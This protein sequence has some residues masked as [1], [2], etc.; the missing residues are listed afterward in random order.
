[1]KTHLLILLITFGFSTYQAQNYRYLDISLR[2]EG[3]ASRFSSNRDLI[4]QDKITGVKLK[5]GFSVGGGIGIKMP[6]AKLDLQIG[7]GLRYYAL[8]YTRTSF[9][10]Y[11]EASV[12][13]NVNERNEQAVFLEV[14]PSAV[15]AFPRFPL[16]LRFG[17]KS[18]LLLYSF[19]DFSFS[20]AFHS[21]PAP[22]ELGVKIRDGANISRELSECCNE[23]TLWLDVGLRYW[24]SKNQDIGIELWGGVSPFIIIPNQVYSFIFGIHLVKRWDH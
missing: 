18:G 12:S 8:D 4:G 17:L 21:L 20:Q 11:R 5:P 14:S 16:D 23:I 19:G 3:I 10:A 22:N 15:Y 13:V 2:S 24:F 6:D 7:A 9:T 1:M